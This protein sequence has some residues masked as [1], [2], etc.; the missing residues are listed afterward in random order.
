MRVVSSLLAVTGTGRIRAKGLL[1]SLH[2]DC[3][4]ILY[5]GITSTDQLFTS[6]DSKAKRRLSVPVIGHSIATPGI[7]ESG[8][9]EFK[10]AA[11][12]A[13]RTALDGL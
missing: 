6:C 1:Y 4:V 7:R 5:F 2:Y 10:K 12:D 8:I 9:Q 11:N 3:L 13:A